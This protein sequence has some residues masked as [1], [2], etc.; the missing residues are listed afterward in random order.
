M[1]M[2]GQPK[3]PYFSGDGALI[4]I[5]LDNYER[6]A[7]KAQLNENEMVYNCPF[8]AGPDTRPIWQNLASY[9]GTAGVRNWIAFRQEVISL[10]DGAGRPLKF[11]RSD[12]DQLCSRYR[13]TRIS[14]INDLQA[15]HRTYMA[16]ASSLTTQGRLA[17]YDRDIQYFN[18]VATSLGAA[19]VTRLQVVHPQVA[20]HTIEQVYQQAQ[21][22]LDNPGLSEVFAGTNQPGTFL[23]IVGTVPAPQF[24]T[25]ASQ[26]QPG[27]VFGVPVQQAPLLIKN[28]P[29]YETYHNVAQELQQLKNTV[30]QLS[31]RPA[32]QPRR[33]FP[34][35][36]PQPQGGAPYQPRAGGACLF[37]GEMGHYM[38]Q[39]PTRDAYIKEGRIRLDP[40]GQMMYS[41]GY[42]IHA[43]PGSRFKDIVDDFEQ[44]KERTDRLEGNANFVSQAY[45]LHTQ[46]EKPE[47]D[48]Q[49]DLQEI[50][51]FQSAED[52]AD[53][54]LELAQELPTDVIDVP[55]DD[56]YY[57]AMAV[58]AE[59]RQNEGRQ[60]PEVVI[61]A[62]RNFPRAVRDYKQPGRIQPPV[63]NRSAPER[64]PG[65]VRVPAGIPPA[66]H[67]PPP[68]PSPEPE[69]EP[70]PPNEQQPQQA[71]PPKP[72][73]RGNGGRIQRAPMGQFVV[74]PP[75]RND[76]EVDKL[77]SLMKKTQITTTIGDLLSVSP[78][79]CENIRRTV[80]PSR[81]PLAGPKPEGQANKNDAIANLEIGHYNLLDGP[82]D[83]RTLMNKNEEGKFVAHNNI[84][85]R[86]IACEFGGVKV[87]GILDKGADVCVISSEL[88]QQT[89]E[90]LTHTK[91]KLQAANG[92]T[93]PTE[94]KVSDV[95][96]KIGKLS[97][98]IQA[99]VVN[100]P[101]FDLL[102]G[103][104][105]YA[106]TQLEEKNYPDGRSIVTLTDP[107]SGKV[108][109]VPTRARDYPR[110]ATRDEAEQN[111][112]RTGEL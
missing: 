70:N 29:A 54:Y 98:H 90:P 10:Y 3:A 9:P 21:V 64:Q 6:L 1:P 14:S 78:G 60:I 101:P 18:I 53:E 41:N 49:Y 63:P 17:D 112:D 7:R 96:I 15:F 56:L 34:P 12:Y 85:V 73:I 97:W 91:M 62:R 48:G 92:Q 100:D 82:R 23:P 79:L 69:P 26:P 32:Q 108:I 68:P 67:P 103:T 40:L 75:V 36:P 95:E 107:N 30:A 20:R 61:P 8:Y 72:F 74:R 86:Q 110:E 45:Y 4:H 2:P 77:A 65:I 28:E 39:C 27:P 13:T 99:Q 102:L 38:N 109:V 81:M 25:A 22:L 76:L 37:C 106:I 105:F 104:P 59:R 57:Q 87:D 83:K 51:H 58:T 11:T 66:P 71:V 55:D 44:T 46:T 47:E 80:T 24:V 31:Q 33:D 94:G 93:N 43:P 50:S 42:R 5:F 52:Y 88:W 111:P 35:R 19:L 16:V 84:P 89:E